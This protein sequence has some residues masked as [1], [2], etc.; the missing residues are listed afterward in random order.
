MEASTTINSG[1]EYALSDDL[2]RLC[3]PQEYKDSNRRLAWV[4]SVCCLFLLIGISGLKAPKIVVK[5]LSEQTEIVPVVF[6]PP[7]E[8]PPTQPQPQTDEPPLITDAVVD[9]PVVATVV[10]ADASTVA[11][12]VPVRGPVILAPARFAPPPP[13]QLPKA[14]AP[15]KPTT[16][17]PSAGIG[18][19]YPDPSYPREELRAQH[20]GTVM[21]NVTV[22]PDGTPSTVEVKDTSG[23]A[24][25]DRYAAQFIKSRWHWPAGEIRYYY[26]PVVFQIR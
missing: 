23:Y 5:P 1:H 6:T 12:A 14:Q 21:L 15:P 11:F 26:V 25:L 24:G 22:D 4:N 18:G 2:A 13:A 19:S 16:F 17:I 20:Q 3:L 8:P 10:A 9:T 7:D